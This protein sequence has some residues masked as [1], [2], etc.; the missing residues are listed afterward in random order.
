MNDAALSLPSTPP[1]PQEP[2]V[3]LSFGSGTTSPIS[4][5]LL[6]SRYG[7]LSDLF[8]FDHAVQSGIDIPALIKRLNADCV[9][10]Q[11]AAWG[12]EVAVQLA[13]STRAAPLALVSS[14][15][16]ATEASLPY[17][18]SEDLVD[19]A[20]AWLMLLRRWP[21]SF[22][23]PCGTLERMTNIAFPSAIKRMT[24]ARLGL[25][26]RVVKDIAT[27]RVDPAL[28]SLTAN[29][30][31]SARDLVQP[32]FA[33]IASEVAWRGAANMEE[34][35]MGTVELVLD[36]STAWRWS[37]VAHVDR[38]ALIKMKDATRAALAEIRAL[39]G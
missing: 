20:Q 4:R 19:M 18:T 16:S 9:T 36:A 21:R 26:T 1:A 8:T 33:L 10:G 27:H 37:A 3:Q 38:G 5:S 35:S 15:W 30:Q 24:D 11:V 29:R 23:L 25:L 39:R 17:C 13:A 31:S 28:S 6:H 22:R 14:L 34:L 7:S 32:I 2:W 12:W